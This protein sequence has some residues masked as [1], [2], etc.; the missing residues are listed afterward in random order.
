MKKLMLAALAAVMLCFAPIGANAQGYYYGDS[1]SGVYVGAPGAHRV[2]PG[3]HRQMVP[4]NRGPVYY[5]SGVRSRR[6]VHQRTI[7]RRSATVVPTPAQIYSRVPHSTSRV[8][9]PCVS[10]YSQN[11]STCECTRTVWVPAN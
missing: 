8:C 10:G 9:V 5:E 6:V 7:V 3:P 11:P 1:R 4:Y 2:L